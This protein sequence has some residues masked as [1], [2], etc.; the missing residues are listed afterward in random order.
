MLQGDGP[1]VMV[2]D[3]ETDSFLA[4]HCMDRSLL[5]REFVQLGS[6]QDLINYLDAVMAGRQPMPSLVLLDLNMP[7]MDGLATLEAVRHRSE[8]RDVPVIMIF[9]NS[10]D[11]RDRQRSLERGAN[12][13]T[14]KPFGIHDYVEFFNALAA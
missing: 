6:G 2:D 4:R 1:I 8:F 5:E 11:P 10:D 9:T 13:F 7:G 14:T 12:E 3:S